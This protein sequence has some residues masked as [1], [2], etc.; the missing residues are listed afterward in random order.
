MKFIDIETD[1]ILT[2]EVLMK[3]YEE[4]KANGYTEA[5]NFDMYVESCLRGTL[6]RI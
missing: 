1:E 4:L 2:V 6:E 5:E 3:E